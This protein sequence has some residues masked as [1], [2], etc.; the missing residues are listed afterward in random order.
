MKHKFECPHCAQRISATPD[1]FGATRSCPACSQKFV[2]PAPEGY[3]A[4]EVRPEHP[5]GTRKEAA[6]AVWQPFIFIGLILVCLL[7]AGIAK[8][9]QGPF[10][11]IYTSASRDDAARAAACGV[12]VSAADPDQQRRFADLQHRLEAQEAAM[13]ELK[14][15]LSQHG[16]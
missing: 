9:D 13:A 4:E 15:Q 1:L 11:V 8:R 3:V 2:V 5:A 6:P 14:T 10:A 16:H 7:L 12:K